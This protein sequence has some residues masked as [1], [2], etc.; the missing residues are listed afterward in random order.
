[1]GQWV[2]RKR[3]LPV[4][5]ARAS[6][7]GSRID[8]ESAG[9]AAMLRACDV[10]APN[11]RRQRYVLCRCTYEGRRQFQA[12]H[13]GGAEML[14]DF[15]TGVACVAA[16]KD[17]RRRHAAHRICRGQ[18]GLSAF[19]AR[20]IEHRNAVRLSEAEIQ[21]NALSRDDRPCAV[22]NLAASLILI[23]TEMQE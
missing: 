14:D 15:W 23:E 18:P 2:R 1:M 17:A 10:I 3:T 4:A 16:I 20:L 5:S 7:R 13:F 19:A 21:R 6:G 11:I 9:P 22:I 8:I 12:P